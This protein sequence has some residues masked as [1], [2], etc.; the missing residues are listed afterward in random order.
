VLQSAKHW[1][2]EKC[3]LPLLTIVLFGSLTLNVALAWKV[4]AGSKHIQASVREGTVLSPLPV[5]DKFGKKLTLN[6]SG[7][8]STVLYVLSPKCGWCQRN[9]KNISTLANQRHGTFRFIGLSLISTDLPKFLQKHPVP[10]EIYVL[11]SNKVANDLGLTTT[12]QTIFIRPDGLVERN[13]VGGL[14][15]DRL[16]DLERFFHITLPGLRPAPQHVTL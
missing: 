13:W 5:I 8:E 10:F 6:F 1:G 16:Q 14:Q 7:R 9:D 2:A 11:N 4:N 12:P 15:G 3:G